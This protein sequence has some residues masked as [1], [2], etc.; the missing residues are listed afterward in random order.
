MRD[1]LAG[2]A[3]LFFDGVT[4]AISNA[5]S[6]RVK[7]IAAATGKRIPVL[8]ELPAIAE[9]GYPGF[10]ALAWNGVMVARG[11]AARR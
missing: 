9:S 10:E 2:E 4:T 3:Q 11:H 7:M 8:P 5:K 6:G 1:H